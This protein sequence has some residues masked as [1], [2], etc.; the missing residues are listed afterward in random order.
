M[1]SKLTAVLLVMNVLLVGCGFFFLQQFSGAPKKIEPSPEQTANIRA[2]LKSLREKPQAKGLSNTNFVYVTNSFHWSHLES[3]DYREY[4]EKLRLVGCPGATIKDIII[5]DIMRLYAARR[6]EFYHNGREFR[7]WETDEKR[8]LKASQLEEREKQLAQIDDEIPTVL[9]ELLG[10][11]YEREINKFFVDANEDERRLNF[12]SEDK[13]DQVLSL[14]DEIEGMREKILGKATGALLPAQIEEMRRIEEHRRAMLAQILSPSELEEFELRTSETA[15]RL[16]G[17]L[18][19]FEPSAEE[20]RNIYSAMKEHDEKFAHTDAD[21]PLI[22]RAKEEE[23]RAIENELRRQMGETR[24]AEY[25]RARDPE[26]RSA[27]LFAELYELPS[28][29]AAHI[30]DIQQIAMEERM[31]L[32]SNGNIPEENRLAA[33]QAIQAETEKSLLRILGTKLLSNYTQSSGS[34]V[35]ELGYS[36]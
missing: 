9:R 21:H 33:L 27:A 32:L 3:A 11:N 29:T 17:E 5:T 15:D 36:N 1:K 18:I 2:H 4:I 13:R 25:Q 22:A 34:W 12:I 19:G 20:F 14:R 7:F 10:I 35:T 28:S 24:Y 26:F 8:K 16:R 6:G 31:N 30:F 23:L